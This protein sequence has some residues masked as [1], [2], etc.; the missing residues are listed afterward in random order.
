VLCANVSRHRSEEMKD[1]ETKS[2]HDVIL[3]YPDSTSPGL[4]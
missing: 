3:D 2:N 1:E 4:T